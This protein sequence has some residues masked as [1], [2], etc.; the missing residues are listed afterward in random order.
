[1]TQQDIQYMS[2]ALELARRGSYTTSPNPCVG[3]VIVKDGEIV[4]EGYHQYA[5]GPHAEVNALAQAGDK[6]KDA[7]CYVTLEP[8]SHYGRTPPCADR[9]IEVGVAKV[10]A[11]MVDPNP[12]VSGRGLKKLEDA[13]IEVHSGLLEADALALNPG[14]IKRMKGQGPFVQCKLASSLDG[15]TALKNGKSQWITASDARQDVQKYRAGAC[16]IVS[17]ADTVLVDDASLNVR[18]QYDENKA[19]RQPVRVI[20]DTQNRLNPAL[21]LFSI[22][23]PIILVRKTLDNQHQWPHFVEQVVVAQHNGKADLKALLSLLADKGLNQ[24]WLEAGAT[25]AGAFIEQGLVDE[26]II[27]QAP[28]LI[29]SHG[30]ALLHLDEYTEMSQVLDLNLKD[31]RMVGQD[32]RIT[33]TIEKPDGQR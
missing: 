12:Q 11:A 3:C 13:G 15:K 18:W 8:C 22:D 2:R 17:G 9:L 7:V 32:L 6:A 26:L 21:K 16:A 28:K 24:V 27:Y 10:V 20:I 25:L 30:R 23:S 19:P 1:M 4:G 31:V 5:G 33:A 14:F 29:G